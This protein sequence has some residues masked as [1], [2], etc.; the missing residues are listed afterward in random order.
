[1]NIVKEIESS[2]F[3]FFGFK[4]N[5]TSENPWGARS[6]ICKSRDG[7]DW[8]TFAEIPQLGSLRDH[9][10]EKYKDWYYIVGTPNLYRTKDF[11]SFEHLYYFGS[12]YLD[13]VWAPE[14]F[15]DKNNNYHIVLT[16]ANKGLDIVTA[17]RKMFIF[18]IDLETGKISNPWME[19]LIDC[20]TDIDASIHLVNGKYYC[21]MSHNHVYVSENYLG[22]YSKL[23][24]NL[25]NSPELWS[26]NG[27]VE[28]P[29][30]LTTN[31]DRFLYV[32]QSHNSESGFVQS[33]VVYKANNLELT[34]WSG[35][36][37]LVCDNGNTEM[38]HGSFM[39]N[40]LESS[41]PIPKEYF[42][43]IERDSSLGTRVII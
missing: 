13:F 30:L 32:D 35:S 10:V 2:P 7:L 5:P 17:K 26:L 14:I 40:D 1:M 38:R 12:D 20:G 8:S 24:T 43:K 6:I 18:D 33:Y 11:I 36:E 16:A 27:Y 22:P 28:G 29:E 19:A 39:F 4:P 15:K 42:P 34:E 41:I 3:V 37:L 23:N 25:P 31:Q 9:Y 21:F